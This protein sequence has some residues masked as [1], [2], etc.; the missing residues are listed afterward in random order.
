MKQLTAKKVYVVPDDLKFR[1]A[2]DRDYDLSISGGTVVRDADNG[3]IVL[4]LIEN[5][6]PG[7]L[8]NPAFSAMYKLRNTTNTNRGNYGG[9]PRQH[10]YRSLKTTYGAKVSS[11]TAGSFESQGGRAR[12]CRQCAWNRDNPK[13]WGKVKKLV[14]HLSGVYEEHAP[15]KFV[16]SMGFADKIHPDWLIPGTPFTTT[17]I[18]NSVKAAYHTDTGDFKGGLG[19]LYTLTKGVVVNWDLVMPEY[20]IRAK[21]K[22][23]MLLLFNPHLWHANMT[24]STGLGEK[25]KQYS[26]ISLVMYAREK[27]IECGSAKEEIQ[28]GKMRAGSV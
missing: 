5:A 10:R 18:N 12:C 6:A 22:N 13:A 23:N 25:N 3:E 28:K 2:E 19:L 20:R 24:D 11:I 17:T 4:A 9:V 15:S 14:Q 26:R 16:N 7:E 8:Y 21:L 27:M 1:F